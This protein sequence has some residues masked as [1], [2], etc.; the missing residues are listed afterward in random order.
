M[1]AKSD[2]C[3]FCGTNASFDYGGTDNPSNLRCSVS[4]NICGPYKILSNAIG[5]AGSVNRRHLVSGYL[6]ERALSK[7]SP[8]TLN[9]ENINQII[10]AAPKTQLER[11]DRFLLNIHKVLDD[12]VDIL[13]IKP[14]LDYTLGYCDDQ[15]EIGS[16]ATILKNEKLLRHDLGSSN[17]LSVTASGFR[18]IREILQTDRSQSKQCFVAMSFDEKLQPIYDN[19]IRPAIIDADFSPYRIDREEHNERI[20]DLIIAELRRSRFIV[21]DFSQHKRGV[22]FEAGFA[23]GLGI[24]VIW[25]C[26]KKDFKK[27]HFDTEHFNHIIW[28]TEQELKEKLYNRIRAVI[29]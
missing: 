26:R 19:A 24:D 4:C 14:G 20:D 8:P 1:T 10:D 7:S 23:K 2:R 17:A 18:R 29:L 5:F 16:M 25:C 9:E 13:E 21:A 27:T 15:A 22:Y 3:P 6:K 11:L 28:E 12:K